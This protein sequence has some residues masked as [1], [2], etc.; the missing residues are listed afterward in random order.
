MAPIPYLSG[1]VLAMAVAAFAALAGFDRD[2]GFYPTLLIVIASYY[3]LFAVMGAD[4]SIISSETVGLFLFGVTAV[5]GFRRNLWIVVGALCCHGLFDAVQ[6][7]LVTNPATPVWWSAFCLAFDVTVAVCL[8]LRI[9]Y[10][11]QAVRSI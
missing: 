7:R 1:I 9:S 6:G 10:S 4:W 11:G 3:A 5:V 2:R 8:A